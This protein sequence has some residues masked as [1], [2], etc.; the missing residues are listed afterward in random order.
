MLSKKS[1]YN[2]PRA[3]FDEIAKLMGEIVPS[4]NNKVP[5]TFYNAKKLAAGLG[6]PYEKIQCCING[7]KLYRGEYR[8]WDHCRFCEHPRWKPKVESSRKKKDV[9]YATMHYL[10]LTPRL[11][12]LYASPATAE[13]MRWHNEH[14]QVLDEMIHPSDAESWKTFDRTFP[15]F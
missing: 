10:P 2:I 14:Q 3:Y 8:D 6:L 15:S 7:C 12:R 4:P 11:Q 9:P 5:K 1:Y 13:H